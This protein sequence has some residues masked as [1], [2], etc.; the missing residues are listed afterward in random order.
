MHPVLLLVNTSGNEVLNSYREELYEASR[1]S[2][3]SLFLFCRWLPI[4]GMNLMGSYIFQNVQ[5]I[6]LNLRTA[7]FV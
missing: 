7:S 5:Y 4:K 1:A 6:P 3:N 2:Y